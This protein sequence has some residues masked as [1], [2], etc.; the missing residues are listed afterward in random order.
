MKASR[1]TVKFYQYNNLNGKALKTL[2]KQ[3]EDKPSKQTDQSILNV[4]YANFLSFRPHLSFNFGDILLF[5][6]LRDLNLKHAF[7]YQSNY[8]IMK[9]QTKFAN[10]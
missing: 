9:H 2:F 8:L 3:A 4:G 5:K 1:F 7:R 10:F 6:V